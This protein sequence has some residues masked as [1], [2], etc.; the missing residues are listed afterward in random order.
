MTAVHLTVHPG[1]NVM[2]SGRHFIVTDPATTTHTLDSQTHQ[3]DD[4]PGHFP[5]D[6]AAHLLANGLARAPRRTRLRVITMLGDSTAAER[7]LLHQ[8]G[9]CRRVTARPGRLGVVP[10]TGVAVARVWGAPLLVVI[11]SLVSLLACVN[12]KPGVIVDVAIAPMLM[13]VIVTAHEGAHW[14]A[15]RSF[16]GPD[17]GALLISWRTCALVYADATARE[18]RIIAAAGPAAGTIASLLAS[19]LV[20]TPAV[21]TTAAVLCVTNILGLTPLTADGR[22]VLGSDT[23]SERS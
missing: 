2:R 9:G 10:V 22:D 7:R 23:S 15:A 5:A 21:T 11:T 6:V 3:A 14:L 1:V 20:P 12:A 8:W 16:R 17:A 19:M 4:R 13:I 18:L